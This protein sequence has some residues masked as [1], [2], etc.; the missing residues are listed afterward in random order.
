[1]KIFFSMSFFCTIALTSVLSH[2]EDISLFNKISWK[3]IELCKKNSSRLE[4]Y[5]VCK[6]GETSSCRIIENSVG[7]CDSNIEIYADVKTKSISKYPECRNIITFDPATND[8]IKVELAFDSVNFLQ[9]KD[10]LTLKFGKPS[11]SFSKGLYSTISWWNQKKYGTLD[12]TNAIDNS[13][14]SFASSSKGINKCAY[15]H[16]RTEAMADADVA[17][18]DRLLQKHESLINKAKNGI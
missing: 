2:A 11:H 9:I 13:T 4:S 6:K 10:V 3:S 16:L 14:N 17:L 1:M 8:V 7:K 15:I 5:E 18:N 12:L